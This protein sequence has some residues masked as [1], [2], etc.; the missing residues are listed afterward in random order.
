MIVVPSCT[1]SLVDGCEKYEVVENCT[2]SGIDNVS[3]NGNPSPN[4]ERT[5]QSARKLVGCYEPYADGI[6][7][8]KVGDFVSA[9]VTVW[10]TETMIVSTRHNYKCISED[11]C[12]MLG[13]G[14]REQWEILAWEKESQECS[15]SLTKNFPHTH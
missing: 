6:N 7:K 3:D 1:P 14:P 11:W 2:D 5:L 15:V 12:G 8:Y 10:K 4:A 9:A 13:Y